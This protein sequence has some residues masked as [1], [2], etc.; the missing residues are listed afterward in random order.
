MYTYIHYIT[1]TLTFTLTFTLHYVTLHIMYAHTHIYIYIHASILYGVCYNY[2]FS[3][4]F[5]HLS[6]NII[7]SDIVLSSVIFYLTE[8]HVAAI[9]WQTCHVTTKKDQTPGLHSW[10]TSIVCLEFW[11]HRAM[12]CI[13][14]DPQAGPINLYQPISKACLAKISRWK[15]AKTWT[16]S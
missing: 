6:I 5:I 8:M 14:Y 12:A 13:W 4:P 9:K 16:R 7:N 2:L 1:L 11:I 15:C 10:E 3:S